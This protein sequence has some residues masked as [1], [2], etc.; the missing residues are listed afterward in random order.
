MD[1]EQAGT[2]D[3]MLDD[4]LPEDDVLQQIRLH[5]AE[6]GLPAIAV[7]SQQGRFLQLLAEIAG[8]KHIL[9]IGT[10]GGYSTT[11]LARALPEEGTLI[12]LEYSAEHARVA[13]ENL[14]TACVRDRVS[15]LVGEALKTLPLLADRI[16]YNVVQPFD[17]VF[18]DADKEN[19]QQYLEWAVKLTSPG[20]TIVVDNVIR[21]GR[22]LTVADKMDFIESLAQHNN[23]RATVMQTIGGKGWDGFV[24]ARRL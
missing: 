3:D 18:I 8:A 12:T 16:K 6:A 20:A 9:E 22:V 17:F 2:V 24:L 14:G 23:L 5:S 1:F 21:D 19:N 13:I 11:C 7:T 4:T 15:V 10:L